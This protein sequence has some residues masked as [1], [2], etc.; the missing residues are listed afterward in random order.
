M[1]SHQEI[2]MSQA[3]RQPSRRTIALVVAMLLLSASSPGYPLDVS[4]VQAAY[5]QAPDACPEPNDTF[6][7]ACYLSP[8]RPLD[9]P[10][11]LSSADDVDA[12]RFEI[13]DFGTLYAVDMPAGPA[14]YR[15]SIADWNGRVLASSAEPTDRHISAM[16]PMPGSYYLFVDSPTGAFSTTEPYTLYARTGQRDTGYTLPQTLF[17]TNFFDQQAGGPSERVAD[18]ARITRANGAIGID[19]LEGGGPRS[20]PQ[21]SVLMTDQH[22]AVTAQDFT[23]TIDTRVVRGS[24]E[25]GFVLRLGFRVVDDRA[26]DQ[27]VLDPQAGTIGIEQAEPNH[28]ARA[29]IPLTASDAIDTTGGVNRV[30]IRAF[31]P[32]V[33]V[34]VNG[35]RVLRADDVATAAGQFGIGLRVAGAPPSIRFD[36][37]LITTPGLAP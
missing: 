36:N 37:V 9:A 28:V 4:R 29:V 11:Y 18:G 24:D 27:V 6:Q 23:W 33:L 2:P 10:S 7:Q 34:Y 30:T 25:F 32:E 17:T 15:V 1:V 20:L 3:Q 31:G 13:G 22:G 5:A 19:M 21:V 8:E 35:T 26:Y 12:Y 14:G 16:L